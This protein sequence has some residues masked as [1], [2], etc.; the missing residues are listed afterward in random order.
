MRDVWRESGIKAILGGFARGRYCGRYA[1]VVLA[2]CT[3][4]AALLPTGCAT[5]GGPVRTLEK[6][7]ALPLALDDTFEFRKIKS[8]LNE[9]ELIKRSEDRM[10]E[11]R[12][13]QINYGAVTGYD[14][15]QR[16]GHYFTFFWKAK[17][18]ADLTFRFEYR[19]ERL[20]SYVQAREIDCPGAKGAVKTDIAIIGDDYIE[21]G[22]ITGWRALLIENGQV[23]GLAQSFLWN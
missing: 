9:P 8:F 12:T 2:A 18:E 5:S 15:S 10:L 23:V 3:G 14:R 19:Q 6:A 1:A 11:F 13:K 21:D 22:K 4:C 20:G 7:E 16:E 17:R